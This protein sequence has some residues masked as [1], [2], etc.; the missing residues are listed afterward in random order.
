MRRMPKPVPFAPYDQIEDEIERLS[1]MLGGRAA[2]MDRLRPAEKAGEDDDGEDAG[3]AGPRI[4]LRLNAE[5]LRRL[6]QESEATRF[7][8]ARWVA[9]LIHRTLHGKPQFNRADRID[10]SKIAKALQ[11]IDAR[12]TKS[13]RSLE[14]MLANAEILAQR[15]AD[16]E[17]MRGQVQGLAGALDKAFQG[18][19]AYWQ[20]VVD[21][22]KLTASSQTA[23][24]IRLYA[25]RKS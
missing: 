14:D 13:A 15:L 6:D 24:D 21:H 20:G 3:P 8:R 12:L 9:A 23:T 22:G 1:R 19:E 11:Q 16:V 7:T 4:L 18:N 2:L 25:R 5:D 10:L 17:R